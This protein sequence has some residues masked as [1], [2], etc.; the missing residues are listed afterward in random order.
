MF[1]LEISSTR[2]NH[3]L[4][5]ILPKFC[6]RYPDVMVQLHE[7]SE[8]ELE[9]IVLTGKIDVAIGVLNVCYPDITRI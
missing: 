1:R 2:G 5:F 9:N 4:P 3:W 8:Q 7:H 6:N